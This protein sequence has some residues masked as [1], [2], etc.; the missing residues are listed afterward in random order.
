MS[1]TVKVSGALVAL[2][3][4]SRTI[5]GKTSSQTV[6]KDAQSKSKTKIH[7]YLIK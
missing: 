5:S 4:M 7:L 2:S 6:V 3:V 1:R